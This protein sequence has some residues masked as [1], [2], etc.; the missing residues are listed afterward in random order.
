MTI[1]L[2][3]TYGFIRHRDSRSNTLCLVRE[4]SVS[5]MFLDAT[6]TYNRGI[7]TK[8]AFVQEAARFASFSDPRVGSAGPIYEEATR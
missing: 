6:I 1:Y 2:S 7:R 5:L 8:E 3:S 4:V